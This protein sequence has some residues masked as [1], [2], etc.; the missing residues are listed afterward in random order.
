MEINSYSFGL[1]VVNGKMY[2]DDLIV[3]PDK[4]KSHWWRKQGHSLIVEDLKEVL[5]YKPKIL[6]VGTGS[7]AVM[8]IPEVTR[9]TLKNKDIELI[10]KITPEAYKIFNQE[11]KASKLVVGA[12]HL[13]C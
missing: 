4:V 2:K 1:M 13:T 6:V 5:E 9:E 11:L 3:F 10:D 8:S 12:F 7:Y